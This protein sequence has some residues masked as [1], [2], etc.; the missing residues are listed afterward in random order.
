MPEKR[1]YHPADEDHT[2]HRERQE[3]DDPERQKLLDED[4]RLLLL[5]RLA[6]L[7]INRDESAEERP[8]ANQ[9]PKEIREQEG[10][11]VRIG[12]R[13]RAQECGDQN[14]SYQAGDAA[15]KG[16]AP[17]HRGSTYERLR[18]RIAFRHG[19][20]DLLVHPDHDNEKP[21]HTCNFA[22]LFRL[23][24]ARGH[25]SIASRYPQHR[26][27]FS[28]PATCCPIQRPAVLVRRRGGG[29]RHAPLLPPLS[30]AKA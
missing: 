18:T 7:G 19:P 22:F 15:E 30:A 9:P 3:Q 21:L 4:S 13:A 29:D 1:R 8:L 5:V 14:R 2:E 16:K 27:R 10:D 28:D 23:K 6:V 11:L 25:H 12:D 24:A 26:I 17:Y 20:D